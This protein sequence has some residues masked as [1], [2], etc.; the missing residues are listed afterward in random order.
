[1]SL[2]MPPSLQNS[3]ALTRLTVEVSLDESN[4]SGLKKAIAT[5]R[6]QQHPQFDHTASA[7]D[8]TVFTFHESHLLVSRAWG[9]SLQCVGRRIVREQILVFHNQ[10]T[11]DHESNAHPEPSPKAVQLHNFG[12]KL[13]N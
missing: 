10:C 1:M 3:Y 6:P 12:A 2:L 9:S 5:V 4:E 11:R 13:C 7:I 8:R